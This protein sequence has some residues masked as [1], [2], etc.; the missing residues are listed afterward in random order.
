[1][2]IP[3]FSNYFSETARASEVNVTAVYWRVR[4]AHPP[5]I[6]LHVAQ[7]FSIFPV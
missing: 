7:G 5:I 4:V 3:T 6:I 2:K 1:M